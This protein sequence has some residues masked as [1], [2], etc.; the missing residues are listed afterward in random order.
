MTNTTE[1]HTYKVIP[2][3]NNIDIIGWTS[4][5]C[6]YIREYVFLQKH[7]TSSKFPQNTSFPFD[8]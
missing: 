1:T 7:K 6:S 3:T 8:P 5:M 2:S 4:F